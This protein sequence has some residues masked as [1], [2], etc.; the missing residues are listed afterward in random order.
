MMICTNIE[1]LQKNI[2]KH[3]QNQKNIGFVPTMGA[4]HDGHLSLIKQSNNLKNVTICSIFVNPTQFNDPTD[5]EKYPKTIEQDLGLLEEANCSI[6]FLPNVK[7]IYPNGTKN[8]KEYNL[9]FL[10][11]CLEGS[12]RPGHFQ[13]VCQ[14][15]E[16]LLEIVQPNFLYLGQKDYQQCMVITQLITLMQLEDKI[17]LQIGATIREP[18]GLAMSSRN[19]RLNEMQKKDAAQIFQSL[20]YIK[21]QIEKVSVNELIAF[22]EKKL[23]ENNFER[24]DY[25]TIC[26][27]TT[28]QPITSFDKNTKTIALIAAF[29]GGVRLID[30]LLLN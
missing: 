8:A 13:G 7:E 10:E 25:I 2:S 1:S 28:L 6:V 20:S 17:N 19:L 12:T 11:Q 27:A 9:G 22:T 21:E 16:R 4:L 5:F 14:V 15:V 24:V 30:N 18:S 23:I 26:N 3:T 29:I